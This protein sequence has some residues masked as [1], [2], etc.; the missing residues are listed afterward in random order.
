MKKWTL[1]A[2]LLGGILLGAAEAR[3]KTIVL[4]SSWQTV[5]IGDVAHAPGLIELVTRRFPDDR[6]VLWPVNIGDGV[7]EMLRR[8]YPKLEIVKGERNTPQIDRLFDSADLFIQ[9]SCQSVG[10]DDLR[11]WRSRGDKPYGLCGITLEQLTPP[12]R[13]LIDHAA[14]FFCR[15]TQ[16][17]RMLRREKVSCPVLEF[18]PDTAFAMTAADPGPAEAFMRANGLEN[19]RFLCVIPRLRYTPYFQIYPDKKNNPEELRK[20]AYSLEHRDQDLAPVIGLI[21]RFLAETDM[22]VVLCPEM[23]YEVELYKNAIYPALSPAERARTVI[24]P[25]FWLPDR[26]IGL[27]RQAHSLVSMEMHSP[28]LALAAGVP[29]FYLQLPTESCKG[30]MM[31]DLGLPDWR[32]FIPAESAEEIWP[33]LE[34]V[35]KDYPAARTRAAAAMDLVRQ[36]QDYMMECARKTLE[37]RESPVRPEELAAKFAA[38]DRSRPRLFATAAGKARLAAA[39][40]TPDGKKL[41]AMI[42]K[43]AENALDF[44]PAERVFQGTTMLSTSRIVLARIN[45]LGMAYLLTGDPRFA[46]R[47]AAEMVNAAGYPDWNPG[48]SLDTAEMTMALALGYDW[49]YDQLKPGERDP[50]RR[51]I[52]EKGLKPLCS[53][54]LWWTSGSNNW[55]QVCHAAAVAGALAVYEDDPAFARAIVAKAIEAMPRVMRN[56]A[57]PNGAYPEGPMYWGY[58]MMFNAA[59][60]EM[61]ENAFGSDFGLGATAGF[62]RIGEYLAAVAAPSGRVYNYGDSADRCEVDYPTLWW[63]AK[64]GRTDCFSALQRSLLD[65]LTASGPSKNP[66]TFDQRLLPLSLFAFPADLPAQ[67][68]TKLPLHYFSGREAAVPF[69]MHRS[70]SSADAAAVAIKGGSPNAPHAHMDV[71]AVIVEA[72][73]VRWLAESGM[74]NYQKQQAVRKDFW[75]FAQDSGRWEVFRLGPDSHNIIRID[76]ARQNVA[77]YAPIVKSTPEET[78]V[79][80]SPV[81]AGQ[82]ASV[83]RRVVLDPAGRAITVNDRLTGLKPGAEVRFQFAT[84][85]EATP[86]EGGK[87]LLKTD[88]K[89]F[90]LFFDAGK[91]PVKWEVTPTAE[92]MKRSDTPIADGKML[93]VR[94]A[95]PA[96]GK[97][98]V[99]L[100]G[101]PVTP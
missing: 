91:L 43:R 73:G 7:E 1:L 70:D 31:A 61:L 46:R 50:I 45:Y 79:D 35:I 40:A 44:P 38:W 14:F 22:K 47:A 93:A 23:S 74:E 30:E 58:G 49:L 4:R 56:S 5:N 90:E 28:I 54:P 81:Y 42:V 71:G 72:D 57:Y 16:T 95:A 53:K 68:S 48:T 36:R 19:Q 86:G 29:S 6:I 20:N 88:G 60:L 62:D 69:A 39:L 100:R 34:R 51:A 2:L 66:R 87:L 96:D 75:S 94:L 78:V 101:R 55:T 92:L 89:A 80:L 65:K 37:K 64:Y 83:R 85:A 18:G 8:N 33:D 11:Y 98:D 63:F 10:G 26:A 82:A 52:L 99:T 12:T 25:E 67:G 24:Y 15:D 77:G 84:V 32:H 59:L 9:G 13:E 21:K 41:A 76:G 27:Y 17:L 97:L 3:P